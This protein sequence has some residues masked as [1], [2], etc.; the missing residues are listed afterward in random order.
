MP[1]TG[2][3]LSTGNYDPY[4]ANIPQME[5]GMNNMAAMLNARRGGMSSGM[6][7]S[8]APMPRPG[9][10]SDTASMMAGL[11]QKVQGTSP[12]TTSTTT[13]TQKANRAPELEA[14]TSTLI[15]KLNALQ[16]G[17]QAAYQEKQGTYNDLAK[18]LADLYGSAGS[19]QQAAA[20]SGALASGLSPLE[21]SQLSG[22]AGL[23]NLQQ[24]FPQLAGLRSEQADVGID[25]QQALQGVGQDYQSM[26]QNIIAPYQ[27]AIAGET[28]TGEQST[29][30]PYRQ[31]ELMAQ[32]TKAVEATQQ[33]M[34]QA[35]MQQNWQKTLMDA[36]LQREGM[37]LERQKMGQMLGVE[38]MREAGRTGRAASGEESS[39][40]KLLMQLGDRGGARNQ[41]MSQFLMG[42]QQQGQQFDERMGFDQQRSTQD[43]MMKLM[44]FNQPRQTGGLNLAERQALE[45]T[46]TQ[47][48]SQIE[49]MK[50]ARQLMGKD[51][52]DVAQTFGTPEG[53]LTGTNI[54]P[55]WLGQNVGLNM[56]MLMQLLSGGGGGVTT[57]QT[58]LQKA[59][60]SASK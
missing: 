40:Q 18:S 17:Y 37:G 30:D 29:T 6:P 45:G 10:L 11:L 16:S 38:Q 25:L 32:L 15:D 57:Q 35:Q 2:K 49:A 48:R 47:G 56:P 12:T 59:I 58:D 9:G 28:R 5:Y 23:Q 33:A 22:Q 8:R 52:Y 26:V 42:Q 27:K 54:G 31:I 51:P 60:A 46:K 39:M 19:A 41:Q 50:T 43:M 44:Q 36:Q 20:G 14:Q 24:Y 34:Q 13:E 55:D 53:L 4:P 1:Q 21:A 3:Q 7:A